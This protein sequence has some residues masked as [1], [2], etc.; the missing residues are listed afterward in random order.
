MSTCPQVGSMFNEGI[1]NTKGKAWDGKSRPWTL[2]RDHAHYMGFI[3]GAPS[4]QAARCSMAP[5]LHLL[6]A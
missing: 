2:E 5:I 4:L 3:L 1:W 6:H